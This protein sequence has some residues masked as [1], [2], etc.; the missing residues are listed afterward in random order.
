MA[1]I[2]Y[3]EI[4]KNNPKP[5]DGLNVLASQ[6]GRTPNSAESG[7]L[8]QAYVNIAN[9][10]NTLGSSGS[11]GGKTIDLGNVM[12][13]RTGKSKIT[14][15]G[16]GDAIDPFK[17]MLPGANK[18]QILQGE[19]LNQLKRE[20]DLHTLIAE[21][22]GVAGAM[23]TEYKNMIAESSVNALKF[24]YSMDQVSGMVAGMS[25][26]TGKANIISEQLLNRSYETSRAFV[27]TLSDLGVMF[28]EFEKVGI[29]ASNAMDSIDKAGRSSMSLG[30]NAKK[31]TETLKNELGKLNEYGFANGVEGLNRMVQRSLE[32]RMNMGEVFKIADKVM[33]PDK[34]IELTAN[35]QMLGGAIGDLNDPLK[36]MYMA[37]NNVEGLQDAMIGA[38]ENLAVYNEEQQRFEVT[39]LNLRRVKEMANAM[40]VDY[41]E[42]TKGAIAAQERMK[43]MNDL[44]G[45]GFDLSEADKELVANMAQ[46]KDGKMTI[47]LPGNVA[48]ELG[49][50]GK[51][52][53][54]STQ[55]AVED[56]SQE[57]I[58]QLKGY[59][60]ELTA[61]STEDIAKGTFNSV[62]Q[63]EKMVQS[64]LQGNVRGIMT[65][66]VGEKGTADIAAPGKGLDRF[67]ETFDILTKKQA[68]GEQDL[69][70]TQIK[71]LGDTIKTSGIM[72]TLI[73]G[74]DGILDGLFDGIKDRAKKESEKRAKEEE[75]ERN[76]RKTESQPTTFNFKH[77]FNLV[78]RFDVPFNLD[79]K[80]S[81]Q[82]EYV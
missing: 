50:V 7:Q 47:T 33:D 19:I 45:K 49:A 46:M 3:Q 44:M 40:G 65:S 42:L 28:T 6:L 53:G 18:L 56:L 81:K 79:Y 58:K 10:R 1:T 31:T 11:Y 72:S 52:I 24:G 70:G 25:E 76:T 54:T 62:T 38:V 27:G 75:S 55:V 37:T 69:L 36:L 80:G 16:A 5:E 71:N 14:D 15:V 74:I 21:K 64:L 68:A 34:A 17:F 9:A 2:N 61:L 73:S 48:K 66:T 23:L 26:R 82:G 41:K 29:G 60:D 43:T 32:F 8:T 35:M 20:A 78:P 39:G 77:D 22:V 13:A 12:E 4:A 67:R 57:Q 51:T 59:Q 30:L 63:I